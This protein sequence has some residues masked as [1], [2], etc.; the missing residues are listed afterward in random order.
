[1]ISVRTRPSNSSSGPQAST[2][3]AWAVAVAMGTMVSLDTSADPDRWHVEFLGETAFQAAPAATGDNWEFRATLVATGATKTFRSGTEQGW[4]IDVHSYGRFAL[5]DADV[6]SGARGFTLY[7]LEEDRKIVEFYAGHPH[8]SPD[9]RY[10]VYRRFM[11]RVDPF[12]PQISVVDLAGGFDGVEAGLA[13]TLRGIGEVVI[14]PVPPANHPDLAG[15]YGTAVNSYVFEHVAW[16]MENGV[17]YFTPKDRTGHLN[18]VALSLAPSPTVSCYVPLTHSRLNGEYFD[19]SKVN[20][21]G[22]A[23]PSPGTVV[24]TTTNGFG[25]ESEHRVSLRKACWEQNRAFAER[26]SGTVRPD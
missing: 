19:V 4:F 5:I 20:P 24:V 9:G 14:P 8:I 25:V 21:K 2:V 10:L 22:I 18:L 17:S 3:C 11:R 6:G 23:V 12:R 7:D 13:T 16:D 26:V 1:M 15:A